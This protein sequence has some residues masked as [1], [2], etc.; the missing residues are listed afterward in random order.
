MERFV[1]VQPQDGPSWMAGGT[2]L[3]ARRI[4]ML[5]DV[6]DGT[7]LEGQERVI[8]RDKVEGAPLGQREEYDQVDLEARGWR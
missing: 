1:W 2:Y 6:W 7:S 5:F 3:V 8:G 4:Q